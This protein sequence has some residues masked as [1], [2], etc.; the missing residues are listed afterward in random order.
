[1]DTPKNGLTSLLAGHCSVGSQR[2]NLIALSVIQNFKKRRLD[3]K[4]KNYFLLAGCF[5]L[6]VL[7]ASTS[8]AQTCEEAF[9]TLE[10][11]C[12]EAP[13]PVMNYIKN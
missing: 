7:I 9:E 13:S 1:M 10:A 5:L 12:T 6:V 2:G 11:Q 3:M 4:R 8:R